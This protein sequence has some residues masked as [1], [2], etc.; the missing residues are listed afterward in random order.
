MSTI[1]TSNQICEMAL[2]K[3]GVF[4]INDESADAYHVAVALDWLDLNMSE[5]SGVERCWWLVPETIS[6]PLTA[7]VADYDILSVL[8]A[9]A[10]DDGIQFPYAAAINNGGGGITP[11]TINR[12]DEWDVISAPG[13]SGTPT[14]IYIDRQSSPTMQTY[15]VLGAGVTGYSVDL[16]FQTF[17]PS[18]GSVKNKAHG[19]RA[20]WQRWAII[21]LAADIGAGPVK[22]LPT[23]RINQ[24][25][26][27]AEIARELLLAFEN[28][29][30]VNKP[31]ADF[32]YL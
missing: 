20:A 17:A 13:T 31:V 5:L 24:Y 10:P 9:A 32:R 30:H 25:R 26:K 2:R 18:V 16:T 3:I 7:E 11:L 1:F 4:A 28:K 14:D 23:A 22:S 27:E 8:G 15:P 29:E 21:Q 12:R 19:L 6:I